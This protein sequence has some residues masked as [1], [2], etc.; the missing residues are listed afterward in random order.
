MWGRDEAGV[1]VVTVVGVVRVDGVEVVGE[2]VMGREVVED[3]VFAMLVF[4][5][6]KVCLLVVRGYYCAENSVLWCWRRFVVECNAR[7]LV[8]EAGFLLVLDEAEVGV[9]ER[10]V[11]FMYT[12]HAEH[13]VGVNAIFLFGQPWFCEST[14][15]PQPF[16]YHWMRWS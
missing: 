10:G 11:W 2:V 9:V 5:R 15:L 16:V 1:A 8:V 7:F 14:I 6:R 4:M 3:G 12:L 13:L